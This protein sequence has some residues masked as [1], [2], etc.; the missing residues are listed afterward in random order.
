MHTDNLKVEKDN[1]CD[2][3][4]ACEEAMKTAKVRLFLQLQNWQLDSLSWKW[5]ILLKTPKNI[6]NKFWYIQIRAQKGEDEVAELDAKA[7]QLETELDMTTEKLGFVSLQVK[8]WLRLLLQI[9]HKL[10]ENI[11]HHNK[12]AQH[13]MTV[14][15][16]V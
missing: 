6:K 13:N 9:W 3:M 5:E 16:K 2:K 10:N 7:K 8:S 4:D 12:L 14:T 1:A 15:I 11:N